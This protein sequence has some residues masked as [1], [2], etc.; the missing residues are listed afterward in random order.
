MSAKK[1]TAYEVVPQLGRLRDQVLFGDVWEQPEL[2]KRDRSLVTVAALAAL[3]R[4]EE[5]RGHIRRAL[6]NGVTA[7]EIRGLVTQIAF[8][9]GWPCGVNAGRVAGDVFA[10]KEGGR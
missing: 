9:A 6:D 1:P 8:Y 5:L 4:T 10:E 2:S 3:Y 7:D